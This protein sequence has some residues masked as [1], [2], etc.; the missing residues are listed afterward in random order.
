MKVIVHGAERLPPAGMHH[1]PSVP[2]STQRAERRAPWQ[3]GTQANGQGKRAAEWATASS[4]PRVPLQ[5]GKLN[6]SK[7]QASE[8][9]TQDTAVLGSS[10]GCLIN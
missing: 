3:R 6:R 10:S 1:V 9:R 8:R 2:H 4:D 7:T 5:A